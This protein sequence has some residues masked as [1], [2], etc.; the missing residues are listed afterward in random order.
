MN[1]TE[2]QK[3]RTEA[4]MSQR[5][6]FKCLKSMVLSTAATI[7]VFV[8]CAI[9]IAAAL[10]SLKNRTVQDLAI[11][12]IIMITYAVFLYVFHMRNRLNTYAE[13]KS[14]F[15]PKKELIAY[16]KA[17]GKI[18]FLLYGVIALVSEL[19]YLVLFLMNQTR[20]PVTFVT[21]FCVGPWINMTIPVLRSVIAVIYSAI[22][23]SLLAVLRSRKVFQDDSF[24]KANRQRLQE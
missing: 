12:A 22:I 7:G 8:V 17:E 5:L 20:N 14:N 2:S 10:N 19:S 15:D 11:K 16:I 9:A 1:T 3:H 21:Q 4:F 23:V 18:M 6:W 24:A 13:H